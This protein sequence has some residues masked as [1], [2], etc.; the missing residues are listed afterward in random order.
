MRKVKS[1]QNSKIVVK[2]TGGAAA[3]VL[4][5]LT[6]I[7]ISRITSKRFLIRHYPYG[8]GGY[9]PL[10]ITDLLGEDEIQ[11]EYQLTKGFVDDIEFKV[12]SIA[13]NH[14]IFQAG[15]NR[16]KLAELLRRVRL[17]T[18]VLRARGEWAIAYSSRKLRKI[19]SRVKTI[20]GGYFPFRDK[21]SVQDLEKRFKSAGLPDIFN[22]DPGLGFAVG[23]VIHYRLG[24]KR[25]AYS[26][27]ELGGAVNGIIDPSVFK[28]IL[29]SQ[30]Y[31]GDIYLVSDE[32][33]LAKEILLEAGIRTLPNP[34]G[35]D[36]WFDL[37]LMANAEILICPW[38]TVSQLAISCIQ[39]DKVQIFYPEQTGDGAM[40]KWVVSN[41]S[42]YKPKYLE[43]S[44]R[45]FKENFIAD[46][47]NHIVYKQ[48]TR[49]EDKS[50]KL[51]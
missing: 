34:L 16:E 22:Q 27:P 2:S 28:S 7:Y 47:L 49:P 11:N 29:E 19:P 9:Y 26:H 38:S 6:A 30:D 43:A 44:H 37:K 13:D 46:D 4:T 39:N 41:V 40:A 25:T 23:V 3:Q 24:N 33:Q 1:L 17:D 42:F 45:I 5:L 36:L 35:N 48:N 15:I 21:S 50:G 18:I 14:P 31:Q 12:G 51:S 20:S 32:P 10:A 8:T